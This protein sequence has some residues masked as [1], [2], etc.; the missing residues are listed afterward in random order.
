[1]VSTR[2]S[3]A[4]RTAPDAREAHGRSDEKA[5]QILDGARRVFLSDGFDSA[6]MNEI[7][8]AA[9]VSKGTLY[10][11]F[12]SKQALFAALIRD[13]RR[14][15]AEQMTPLAEASPDV[16]ATLRAFGVALMKRMTHPDVLAQVRTVIAVAPK[17]PEIGRAFYESG[18][19]HGR[20]RLAAFLDRQMRAGR[21]RAADPLAA[22]TQFLQMCQGDHYKELMFCVADS[23]SADEIEAMASDAVATFMAAYRC[24][25]GSATA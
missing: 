9:G 1:M 22:A 4:D 11:Y 25:P 3:R 21:L 14:Q 12:E 20:D 18:P 5:R 2:L 15:Q 16:A 23:V 7:A 19:L 13:E 24:E 6:S 17:F 8:R 10:V